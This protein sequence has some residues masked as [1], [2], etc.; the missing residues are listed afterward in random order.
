MK[1]NRSTGC[2]V[3]FF[4]AL[5]FLSCM[6]ILLLMLCFVHMEEQKPESQHLRTNYSE[7]AED[8]VQ[9]LKSEALTGFADIPV[10][11]RLPENARKG[12]LPK[13]A[14]FGVTSDPKVITELLQRAAPLLEEQ[15]T[16]WSED[17]VLLDGTDIRYYY[18]ETILVLCWKELCGDQVCTFAEVKIADGSQLRRKLADNEY[19]ADSR[20][21]ASTMAEEVNAVVAINGDFYA[22]RNKGI[23][24]YG[25]KIYRFNPENV[26]SCFFTASGDLLFA[27]LNEFEDVAAAERFVAENDIKFSVAF[28]PILVENGVLQVSGYAQYR[29][30]EPNELHYR[31]AVGQ[32]DPL[33]YL[34]A[35]S[36]TEGRIGKVGT[37]AQMAKVM[38]DKGCVQAYALDG[39]QT[40]EIV[41]NREPV[42]EIAHGSERTMS[43]IIWFGTALPEN[44]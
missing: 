44:R 5:A 13:E 29:L 32:T 40:A 31:S 7:M 42:N 9:N 1:K 30:G 8:A 20:Y 28:G 21:L 4:S 34:L 24:V 38:L 39:G 15:H 37:I 43:D 26:E 19:G 35:T 2:A 23:S 27:H 25:R 33:H 10:H 18:D 17:T 16:V 36:G 14:N 12:N 41:M 22:F 11:Y 6:G 3:G